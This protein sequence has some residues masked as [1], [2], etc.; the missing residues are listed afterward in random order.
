MKKHREEIEQLKNKRSE[1]LPPSTRA[2]PFS[3]ELMTEELSKNFE[4]P[5]IEEYDGKG[6]LEDHLSRFENAA[7]LHQYTDSI[8]FRVFLTTLTGS[9]QR[10]FNLLR[11]SDIK[12]FSDFSRAFLHQFTSSKKHPVTPF[13]L[14]TMRQYEHESLRV[15]I[16]WFSAVVIEVSPSTSD[17][18][19]CAF[20]QGLAMEDFLK[21]FIKKLT[22]TYDELFARTDKYVNLEEVQLARAHQQKDPNKSPRKF[23]PIS[24]VPRPDQS[25]RPEPLGKFVAYTPLKVSKLRALSICENKHLIQRPRGNDQGPRRPRSD[26][27]CDFHKDYEHTTDECKH[28]CHEIE[29]IVHQDAQMKYIL[30]QQGSDYGLPTLEKD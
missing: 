12:A 5:N 20:V 26:R 21:S 1:N 4:F 14:F 16:R 23:K 7:L 2:I 29:R 10:W 18:L 28:L 17:L 13:S 25:A 9:V 24:S 27:Y 19:I 22:G 11:P 8:K 30:T 3:M 15:Y 6:D